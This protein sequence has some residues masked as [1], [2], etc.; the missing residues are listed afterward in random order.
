MTKIYCGFGI[1]K[2]YFSSIDDLDEEQVHRDKEFYYS[3]MARTLQIEEKIIFIL[4]VQILLYL[5]IIKNY[6]DPVKTKAVQEK[7]KI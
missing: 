1:S 4:V 2:K 3:A 6:Y 5:N 7:Y